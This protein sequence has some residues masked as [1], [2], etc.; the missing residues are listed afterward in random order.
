MK[1]IL[2]PVE[3]HVAMESVFKT[4]LRLAERFGSYMEGVALGPDLSQITKADFSLGGIV[5]DERTRRELLD[6][7]MTFSQASWRST[8]S[9]PRRRIQ[10][11]LLSAGAATCWRLMK[12]SAKMAASS[13]S[14]P[15]AARPPAF[16]SRANR[17]SN[18]RF[19][20]AAGR[21]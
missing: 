21:C 9:A 12:R 17:R 1:S 10:A 6:E 5:F 16:S 11:R 14:S 18:G 7:H 3:D 20:N 8:A 13:I 4:A 19:S 2:I 15:S